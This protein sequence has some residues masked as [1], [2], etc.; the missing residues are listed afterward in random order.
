MDLAAN[1]QS[2]RQRVAAACGRSRRDPASVALMAVSKGHPPEAIAAAAG[3]GLSL[4]GESRVQEAKTKIPQCPGR[5]H[6][7]MIGHLQTNKC[8]DAVTLFS[9][10]QSVDSLRL[11][12]EIDKWAGH[13]AKTMP[14][15]LEI[16]VAGESSKYGCSP[17][18]LLTEIEQI[19][20]LP[21][22][23][24]HGLMTVAPFA[25][26]PEK[27]RPVFRRLRD[28]KEQCEKILGAPLPHLSMGMSGD[29]EVAIEEGA[30]MIRVGSALFGARSAARNTKAAD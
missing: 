28:L 14:V 2:V 19:N 22:I 20:A 23:E 30:T 9:M 3:L 18:N 10:I 7:Q 5:L 15:L 27:V 17:E 4:F 24:I 12:A 21:R 11:A 29:F 6:W 13:F 1:L 26:D 25:T 16:N 8:R